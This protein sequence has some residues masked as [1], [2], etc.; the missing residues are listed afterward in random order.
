MHRPGGFPTSLDMLH[1]LMGD[2][3]SYAISGLNDRFWKKFDLSG[4][5]TMQYNL[6]NTAVALNED[7]DVSSWENAKEYAVGGEGV[8]GK[9]YQRGIPFLQLLRHSI[10]LRQLYPQHIRSIGQGGKQ[11]HAYRRQQFSQ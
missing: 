5:E 8:Y 1:Y 3:D 2:M 6:K 7:Y 4:G 11:R 10:Q 9:L